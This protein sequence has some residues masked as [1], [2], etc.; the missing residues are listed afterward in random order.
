MLAIALAIHDVVDEIHDA[1]E[2]AEDRERG[3]R[4][5]EG[6]SVEQTASNRHIGVAEQQAREHQQIFCP[7][8]GT[9]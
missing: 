4:T 3:R 1:R 9:Q 5:H 7:L 8:A 6:R 2:T